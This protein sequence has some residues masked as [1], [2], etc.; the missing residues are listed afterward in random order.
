MDSR[1]ES[2]PARVSLEPELTIQSIDTCSQT[3]RAPEW[4]VR[5][6]DSVLRDPEARTKTTMTAEMIRGALV[7]EPSSS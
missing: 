1:L 7:G 6:V 4:P 5:K 2:V 3:L